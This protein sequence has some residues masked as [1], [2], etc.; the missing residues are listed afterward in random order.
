[1]GLYSGG[2]LTQGGLYGGGTAAGRPK[3]K[4][5]P[6]GVGGF[7]QN[8]GS[9]VTDAVMGLGPGLYKAVTDPV[10]TAKAIGGAY[11]QTYGP[12]FSGD[13]GKFF[14]EVYKHPLGPLLDLATVV[15]LG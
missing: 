12:L 3:A 2:S 11:K 5:E 1:M 8:L 13:Y 7:V 10:E 9:D 4:K 15:T 14:G 6:S